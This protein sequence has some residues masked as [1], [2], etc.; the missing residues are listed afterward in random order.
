MAAGRISIAANGERSKYCQHKNDC[1]K[2]QPN[3]IAVEYG[4]AVGQP[5]HGVT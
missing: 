3:D 1:G 5:Q 2:S 4:E